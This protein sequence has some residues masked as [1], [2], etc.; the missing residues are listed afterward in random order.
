VTD[1]S[2]RFVVKGEYYLVTRGRKVA[3]YDTRR[4]AEL[5]ELAELENGEKI[6][7]AKVTV[8]VDD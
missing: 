8:E 4:E 7:R 6:V 3:I 5:G 2:L 1:T